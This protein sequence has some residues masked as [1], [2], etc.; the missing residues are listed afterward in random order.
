M[1]VS[2]K[3]PGLEQPVTGTPDPAIQRLRT[4]SLSL[5]RAPAVHPLPGPNPQF[6]SV[7]GFAFW[8]TQFKTELI[9]NF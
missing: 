1:Q 9:Q 2:R 5:L 3:S 7:S 4:A 8:Q 6:T